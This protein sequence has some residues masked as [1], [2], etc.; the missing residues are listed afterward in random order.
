MRISTSGLHQ[1][2][3]QSLL[4]NQARLAKT[5]N[6][7]ALGT[8]LL[9]AADDPASWSRAAGVDAQLAQTARFRTNAN[10]A[11]LRLGLEENALTDATESLNR[12]RE[13]A[14]QANS[15]TH[16]VEDRRLIAAEMRSRLESLL[17][18]ANTTDGQGRYLFAG[19]SDGSAPFSLD[20]TSSRYSGDQAVATLEISPERYVALGDAGDRVFQQLRSGNGTFLVTTGAD[21]AGSVRLRSGELEDAALW[22]GGTYT[23]TFNGGNY[24]VRD[25]DDALVTSGAYGDGQS[26]RFR[27]VEL[28]AGGTPADGDTLVVA[29]STQQDVFASID[30]LITMVDG[31][32]ADDAGRAAEQTDFIARFQELDAA[33]NHI[34]GVRGT[35]GNRLQA[36]D[37]ALSQADALDVQGEAALMELRDL[38]YAEAAARLNMQMT[39]LQAAQQSYVRVQGLSLFD[40][41]R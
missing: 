24:E 18:A 40:F 4:F 35:V 32:P 7:L 15:A 36:V 37:E 12:I 31:K 25:A 28:T 39:A 22:D 9:S 2:A 41:L 19:S 13:L 16:T 27:G 10:A 29:P 14:V 38:D 34:S 11:Q 3:L 8:R 5:Q 17:A 26:I 21:N 20:G 6:Q 1:Q 23:V 30:R 33:L